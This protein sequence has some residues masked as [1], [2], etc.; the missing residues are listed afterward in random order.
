[1]GG[2]CSTHGNEERG[3]Q[4]FD[5]ETWGKETTWKVLG[6]DGKIV[7]K[8]IFKKWDGRV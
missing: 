8:W 4:G 6:V 7:L 2:S 3:I 5:G 1:M